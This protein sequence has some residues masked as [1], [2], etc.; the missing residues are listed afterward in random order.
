MSK[1]FTC[2]FSLLFCG[3]I[4][5]IS[6]QT[7]IDA[8]ITIEGQNA[9]VLLHYAK[10]VD[11]LRFLDSY[12]GATG[13]SSR[14]SVLNVRDIAGGTPDVVRSAQDPADFSPGG[15]F[16]R[17]GYQVSLSPSPDQA[18]AAHVSWIS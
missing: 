10:P 17:T 1:L 6:G 9:A 12:A 7:G 18:A 5:H 3:A 11:G 16:S 4:S 8:T 14:I 15:E 13:L 2:L